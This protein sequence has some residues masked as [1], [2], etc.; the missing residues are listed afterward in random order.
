MVVASCGRGLSAGALA[1]PRR[2]ARGANAAWSMGQVFI[3]VYA[4][5]NEECPEF[6]VEAL[7]APSRAKK[8]DEKLGS[9][10]ESCNKE[11]V[12]PMRTRISNHARK[13]FGFLEDK[14]PVRVF[15]E[16]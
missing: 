10:H 13:F 14:L 16:C 5:R 11:A 1:L 8:R 15:G 12:S 6:S 9:L 4:P 2:E 3:K 7:S